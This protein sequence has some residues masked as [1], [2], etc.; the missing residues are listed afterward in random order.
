MEKWP[1]TSSNQTFKKPM[2]PIR[3]TVIH[4]NPYSQRDNDYDRYSRLR[5]LASITVVITG[6]WSGCCHL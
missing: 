1:M 3:T 2:T 6:G 4:A 5:Q